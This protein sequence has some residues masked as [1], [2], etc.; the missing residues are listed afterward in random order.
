M[1]RRGDFNVRARAGG[2]STRGDHSARLG[3]ATGGLSFAGRSADRN[4]AINSKRGLEM[5]ILS[6]ILFVLALPFVIWFGAYVEF[7]EEKSQLEEIN[8]QPFEFNE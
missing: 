8:L 5:Q 1:L 7:L 4:A 3:A 2:C 6:F